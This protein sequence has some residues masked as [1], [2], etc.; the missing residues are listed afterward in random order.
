MV[1]LLL[2]WRCVV[3]LFAFNFVLSLV[4]VALLLLVFKCKFSEEEP[5]VGIL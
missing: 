4:S 1:L 3:S 5:N 2:L